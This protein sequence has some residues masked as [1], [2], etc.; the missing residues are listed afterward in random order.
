MANVRTVKRV[1]FYSLKKS[2][3]NAKLYIVITLAFMYIHFMLSPIK[4]FAQNVDINI[5]P[6][7]FPFLLTSGYS[8]KIFLLLTT[9]LFC[10]APFFDNAHIY[11]LMRSGRRKW[12]MGQHLYIFVVSGIYTLLLIAMTNIVLFPNISFENEWGKIIN[13]FAQTGIAS[14]HGIAIPFDYSIILAFSPGK[15]LVLEGV[16][17]WLLFSFFGN[18]I[19][20]LN[21][22][23]SNFTGNA[24]AVCLILFQFIAEEISPFLT[25]F[26]PASWMSFSLL[27]I[28]GV[29]HYPTLL[30]AFIML[31][32]LNIVTV[33]FS[34]IAVRYRTIKKNKDL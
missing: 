21:L 25:Y 4:E 32:E 27:D 12:C 19:F 8:I 22:F 14:M 3:A 33:L 26:S 10:D 9:L 13:T 16:L 18:I 6:Y 30:Y 31:A 29:N 24:V 20:M 23:V 15:A 11:V 28:N 34:T 2:I 7:V 1:A 5:T 17:C